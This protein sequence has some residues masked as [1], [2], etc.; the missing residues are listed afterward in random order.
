MS[1]KHTPRRPDNAWVLVADRARA[2][3]F[4]TAW[5]TD[6]TCLEVG[7]LIDDEAMLHER[8]TGS[9]VP[10]AFVSGAGAR[11]RGEPATDFAH[12]TAERFA[13]RIVA[14][15]E[16][17]RRQ[18]QFGQL[19]LVAPALMLGVLRGELTPPLA[20]LVVEELDRDYTHLTP[21]ELFER[22]AAKGAT[23]AAH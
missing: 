2:R 13:R 5:P 10:S 20:K 16:D 12:R 17:G 21:G 19:V 11:H 8:D 14:R 7:D 3:L 4:S 15:L 1:Y 18:D 22:L 9:D 23:P 6:G